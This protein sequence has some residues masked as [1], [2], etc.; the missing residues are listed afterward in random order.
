M[1]IQGTNISSRLGG[2]RTRL[3]VVIAA[4][5]SAC[6]GIACAA[7]FAYVPNTLPASVSVIDTATNQISTT[8][9]FPS[10]SNPFAAAMTPDLKKVYVT[11]QNSVVFD[12]DTATNTIGSPIAVGAQAAG[13]AIT[14]DGKHAYVVTQYTSTVYVID[15]DTDTVSATISLPT[16]SDLQYIAIA[17][18]GQRA[19]VTA[20][21]ANAVFVVDTSTNTLLGTPISAG[22]APV[23]IAITPDGKEIYVTHG[24][25]T[26]IVSVIDAASSTVVASIPASPWL[27]GVTFTPDGKLA[28]VTGGGGVGYTLVIDTS[29]RGLVV[30]IPQGGNAVAITS[31]G[32]QAYLPAANS[33]SVLDTTTNT[34]ASTINGVSLVNNVSV[35]PL[36][37]GVAVPNVVGDAQSAATSTIVGAGLTVGT[38]TPQTS[39]TVV[40]GVVI[41]QNPASAAFLGSSAAVNLVVSNGVAVPDV[42]GQTQAAATGAFTAAGLVVGTVTQQSSSTVASG[43]VISQSPTAGTRLAGG[44]TVS[45][46]VSSGSPSGGGGGGGIDA[47]TSLALLCLLIVALRKSQNIS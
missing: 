4:A 17:P 8:V 26:A 20:K 45:L 27:F 9:A 16:G 15:T 7:P 41:S 11:G 10:M 44:A 3:A 46:V 32:K 40:P 35:R 14:P 29:T 24:D 34:V 36:P 42:A 1:K 19:Y 39:S 2:H 33:V 38:V 28:Y 23:G 5:L 30:T 25:S 43:T 13:I 47:L 21:A 6:A 12:F 22:S 18:D 37:S 31:D